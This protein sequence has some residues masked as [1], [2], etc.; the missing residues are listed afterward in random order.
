[1]D[2]RKEALDLV[3]KM[4][5]D[6]THESLSDVLKALKEKASELKTQTYDPLKKNIEDIK[7][8]DPTSKLPGTMLDKGTV[9]GDEQ[10]SL[11]PSDMTKNSPD[12]NP[13]M[14]MSED[15]KPHLAQWMKKC[16]GM[17]KKAQPMEKKHI[18]WDK[19]HSKLEHEG[20]S[21]KSADKIAGS[22]KAKVQKG[23]AV[24]LSMSQGPLKMPAPNPK[25]PVMNYDKQGA[26][27]TTPSAQKKIE[28]FVNKPPV[29]KGDT[30]RP[31]AGFGSVTVKD[32]NPAPSPGKVMVKDDKPHPPGSPE[33]KAHDIVEE[34]EP[35]KE[36]VQDLGSHPAIKKMFE[37]LR[38]RQT[39]GKSWE[40]S[41]ANEA[42]GMDKAEMPRPE[43]PEPITSQA[44]KAIVA[45]SD[46][47]IKIEDHRP[48][49]A[50]EPSKEK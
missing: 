22:I 7:K 28:N 5:A 26:K 34:H 30:F 45:S 18:G 13:P 29:K 44:E 11:T 27:P 14:E 10:A 12:A 9:M 33:D 16:M 40:R 15:K 1:M 35:I 17:M 37:H 21:D 48:G 50:N 49:Q 8:V 3:N 39:E 43:N 4:I 38:N 23:S 19:L 42:A 24:D 25:D 41:P 32:T 6:Q 46:K 31:D 2:R 36:A 47:P 20:Y